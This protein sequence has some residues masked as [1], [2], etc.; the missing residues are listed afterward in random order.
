M[1]FGTTT[2][3]VSM[4]LPETRPIIPTRV[5]SIWFPPLFFFPAMGHLFQ[6]QGR[7]NHSIPIFLAVLVASLFTESFLHDSSG[8][9]LILFTIL[10]FHL[11]YCFF[12]FLNLLFVLP[13]SSAVKSIWLN[14]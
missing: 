10:L 6:Y 8:S 11:L 5:I 9:D 1:T 4:P 3:I 12:F 2:D 14:I 13:I 7:S